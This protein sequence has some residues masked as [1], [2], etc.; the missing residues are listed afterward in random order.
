MIRGTQVSPTS[1]SYKPAAG[2]TARIDAT[3]LPPNRAP[4]AN[5]NDPLGIERERLCSTLGSLV[6]SPK[7]LSL[8]FRKQRGCKALKKVSCTLG[9]FDGSQ[10][11]FKAKALPDGTVRVEVKKTSNLWGKGT[12]YIYEPGEPGGE[13]KIVPT[14]GE[15]YEV[16][17]RGF[18]GE[19]RLVSQALLEAIMPESGAEESDTHTGP[20]VGVAPSP[21][22]SSTN[23]APDEKTSFCSQV[24]KSLLPCLISP[25]G[26]GRHWGAHSVAFIFSVIA[27]VPFTLI[28]CLSAPL[29]CASSTIVFSSSSISRVNDRLDG[30]F[31]KQETTRDDCFN[32]SETL[33]L[34]CLAEGDEARAADEG[35]GR[36]KKNNFGGGQ[37]FFQR[38]PSVYDP[39]NSRIIKDGDYTPFEGSSANVY[40]WKPT[41]K[42]GRGLAS[43][44]GLLQGAGGDRAKHDV[45]TTEG[46]ERVRNNGLLCLNLAKITYNDES[47]ALVFIIDNGKCDTAKKQVIEYVNGHSGMGAG[48]ID[49]KINAGKDI[50][51]VPFSDLERVEDMPLLTR[52]TRAGSLQRRF[53]D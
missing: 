26:V 27:F 3:A 47:F 40:N 35:W 2:S 31:K 44:L 12:T 7:D 33:K 24:F 37:A 42:G 17:D 4:T 18:G 15:K 25:K 23:H 32:K 38:D 39:H 6:G 19:G 30:L 45:K 13:G 5:T 41:L 49:N 46:K 22:I 9:C 10:V 34:L 28:F 11:N 29:P 20:P 1:G 50:A 43:C 16:S 51:L 36:L 14:N 21:L 8:E 53:S 48:T 52:S